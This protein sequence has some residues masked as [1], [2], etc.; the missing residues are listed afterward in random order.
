[1]ATSRTNARAELVRI[2][3]PDSAIDPAPAP[4][5][6]TRPARS[7]FPFAMPAAV[8]VAVVAEGVLFHAAGLGWLGLLAAVAEWVAVDVAVRRNPYRTEMLGWAGFAAAVAAGTALGVPAFGL[9]AI[10]AV[11][12]AG[13]RIVTHPATRLR[14]EAAREAA[15][16]EG[17]LANLG[18]GFEGV[19]TAIGWAHLKLYTPVVDTGVGYK[20]RVMVPEGHT[21]AD[22]RHRVDELTSA[23]RL[24]R[25]QVTVILDEDYTHLAEINVREQDPRRAIE[26]AVDL[27]VRSITEPALIGPYDDAEPFYDELFT[28]DNGAVEMLVHGFKGKGK[29]S[30]VWRQ[31]DQRCEAPDVA[32]LFADGAEGRDFKPLVG[33][34]FRY[35]DTPAGFLDLLETLLVEQGRRARYMAERGWR[36]WKPSAD[37]PVFVLVIDEA[38]TFANSNQGPEIEVCLFTL[39]SKNRATGISIEV[40]TPVSTGTGV[41]SPRVKRLFAGKVQF[42]TAGGPFDETVLETAPKAGAFKKASKGTFIAEMPEE[43]RGIPVVTIWTPDD[44]REEIARQIAQ[45]AARPEAV[46]EAAEQSR[47][48]ADSALMESVRQPPAVAD[49]GVL[50]GEIVAVREDARIEPVFDLPK[51]RPAVAKAD[52]E[53]LVRQALREAGP[54]G[55]SRSQLDD[56]LGWKRTWTQDVIRTMVDAR[57]V[58]T[59]G[60]GSARRYV[61]AAALTPA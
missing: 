4:Q 18:H 11:P 43:A 23:L 29:S 50:T 46:W 2:S 9:L 22:L 28:R 27:R 44:A 16:R 47:A 58:R 26:Q 32:W 31:L 60:D 12:A 20:Y 37:N 15:E 8:A 59:V 40:L 61:L 17:R 52:A 19:A 1:M 3:A 7:A 57:I 33:H 10:I 48:R 6:R 13:V 35:V 25:G 53:P 42:P 36:V 54:A 38:P 34:V 5:V 55:L 49:D 41:F 30:F 24:K 45:N 14:K 51:K 56:L 21:V 39:L